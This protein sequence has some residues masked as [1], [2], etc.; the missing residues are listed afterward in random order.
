MTETGAMAAVVGREQ[1]LALVESFL[2]E[3]REQLAVLVLEGETGPRAARRFRRCFRHSEEHVA[4]GRL[5][6]S[7]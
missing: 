7:F 2:S 4:I 5:V 1:E 6:A 3:E